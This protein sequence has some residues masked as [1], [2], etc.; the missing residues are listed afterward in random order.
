MLISNIDSFFFSLDF[1]DYTLGNKDLL[2]KLADSKEEAKI[3]RLKEVTVNFGGRKF[4]ILPNGSRFHSYIL[5]N[6]NLEIKLARHR[7]KSR[8]NFPVSIRLKS[9][10][11]WE[12]GFLNAYM[13]TIDF[14]ENTIKGEI[15]AD[16]ISR[17][18]LCCHTDELFPCPDLKLWRGNFRKVE[19]FTFNRAIT[20]FSFGTFA[21]KNVMCRI[22]DKTLEIK[23]SNKT[24]F[25]EIWKKE[26]MNINNV[27][28]VEFQVGRKFFKDH[29]IDNCQDFILK[30]RGIW[31]KLTKSWINYI[32]NDDSNI[33]RC[34]IRQEWKN[35]QN[36]YLN[37]CLQEPIKREEQKNYDAEKLIPLLVGVLTSYGACKQNI[38][39]DRVIED[40]KKDVDKYLKEKK[41]N[42]PIEK[43]FYDKLE[44][45]YG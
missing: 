27:W 2:E 3:D 45:L 32:E 40:F 33:S 19:L 8:N 10:Y 13:E 36:A 25:N 12:K 18:D 30:M 43:V 1:E 6:D 22:Y 38:V 20:G 29:N 16:K 34:S 15:I 5:H 31:E 17:A 9:L 37:Y 7:S 42:M 35:I 23:S 14:I 44:Y 26:N 4:K 41:A 11:L 39:L 21:E 24:W 28:N